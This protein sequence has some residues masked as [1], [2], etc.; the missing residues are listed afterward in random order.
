MDLSPWYFGLFIVEE[1]VKRGTNR[2]D[3]AKLKSDDL[4]AGKDDI[5]GG[6]IV[7][8][9]YLDPGTTYCS[10]TSGQYV[11]E[12]P[13]P[14]KDLNS[15]MQGYICEYL[16]EFELAIQQDID[17]YLN[18][19]RP[20]PVN[21]AP[22]YAHL[23][24]VDSLIDQYIVQELSKNVDQFRLSCYF[25]KDANGIL[26]SGPLWD[27]DIAWG[28][29]N[30]RSGNTTSGYM[31]DVSTGFVEWL[32]NLF[33]DPYFVVRLVARWRELRR[34]NFGPIQV[35]QLFS[36]IDL[37]VSRIS[38][39]ADRNFALWQT[40]GRQIWPNPNA[41][42][43]YASE[44]AYFKDFMAARIAWLDANFPLLDTWTT[45]GQATCGNGIVEDGE[46]CDDANS[47]CC[48]PS[49]C[50]FRSASTMCWQ[51]PS[52]N[53]CYVSQ[54]CSGSSEYCPRNVL[55]ANCS[56]SV[57]GNG[58]VEAGEECD[59]ASACCSKSC[60]FK[61]ITFVCQPA[62]NNCEEDSYCPGDSDV[63]PAPLQIE[64]CDPLK[65]RHGSSDAST[66]GITRVLSFLVAFIIIFISLL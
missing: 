3:I 33:L 35:D 66:N 63:C 62:Q 49:T 5:S 52:D 61:K 58:I 45:P 23:I 50:T 42:P 6:Y 60:K 2:V 21:V 56:S 4:A 54:Y 51:A 29:A 36:N 28:A 12:T 40:L 30:Y 41:L 13:T 27:F 37:Q 32:K 34:P 19:L 57:C 25:Y 20:N 8:I 31:R 43:D 11:I 14:G 38:S 17:D 47:P 53:A 48:N 44:I 46:Q 22:R 9:N 55:S 64:G 10:A 26:V 65:P 15:D 59:S 39:A 18:G 24:D 7:S 16:K 1:T